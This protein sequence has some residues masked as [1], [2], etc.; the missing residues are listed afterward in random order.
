[1]YYYSFYITHHTHHYTYHTSH[2]YHSK[3]QN[4]IA[5]IPLVMLWIPHMGESCCFLDRDNNIGY[6]LFGAESYLM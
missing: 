3:Q 1:M 2:L 6:Y 5:Y 4:K